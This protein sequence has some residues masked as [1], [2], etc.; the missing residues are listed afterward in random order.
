MVDDSAVVY[1]VE[2]VARLGQVL[3]QWART[4]NLEVERFSSA[5]AFLEHYDRGRLGCLVTRLK[6]PGMSGQELL[7]RLQADG[8]GLP[9]VIV[10]AYGTV[11]GAVQALQRGAAA[12]LEDPAPREELWEI[13]LRAI[14]RHRRHRAR[15]QHLQSLRRRFQRLTDGEHR[16]LHCVVQGFANK[17]IAQQLHLGLRTVELRRASLMKKLEVESLAGL[18]RSYLEL[19]G[20]DSEA[21]GEGPRA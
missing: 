14:E 9:V 5:E 2:D 1:V 4:R 6:L 3:P 21:E 15:E 16:V 19:H 20:I 7:E 10:T 18:I 17:A 13:I 8:G 12:F 11:Q